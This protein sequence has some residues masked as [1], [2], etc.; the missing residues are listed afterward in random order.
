MK[1][2]IKIL[3]FNCSLK[4]SDPEKNSSTR[5]LLEECLVAFAEE[6][7]AGEIVHVADYRVEPGVTND[8][9]SGDQWPELR[10][11]VDSADIL[12]IGTPIWLGQPSSLAKRVLERL[13]IFL[14]EK[15]EKGHMPSYGKVA[16]LAVVG[17]EDGAHYCTA[18]VFQALNDLGFTIPPNGM[19][20]WVG[21]VMGSVDYIH[22][23]KTPKVVAQMTKSM[24]RTSTHLARLLRS[25]PF[26]PLP[27]D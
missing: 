1:A 2:K 3:A 7:A 20:Y 17:N 12:L 11:K 5:R 21:E 8:E 19:T 9:G 26:P 14:E 24:A 6:G 4:K 10:Q 13:D 27:P 16:T 23:S 15:N 18:A 22:L 25:R